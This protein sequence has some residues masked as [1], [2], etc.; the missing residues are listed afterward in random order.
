MY[1]EL[2]V[3][4]ILRGCILKVPGRPEVAMPGL[5]VIQQVHA[6]VDLSR[7]FLCVAIDVELIRYRVSSPSLSGG[8]GKCKLRHFRDALRCIPGKSNTR[9]SLSQW[10]NRCSCRLLL[11]L[12]NVLLLLLLELLRSGYRARWKLR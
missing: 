4:K 12:A 8:L 6:S 7:S 11:I 9:R 1:A 5:G 2:Q 3:V 10:L